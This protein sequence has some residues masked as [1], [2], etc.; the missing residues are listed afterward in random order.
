LEKSQNYDL[1]D[2]KPEKYYF[3]TVPAWGPAFSDVISY[4]DK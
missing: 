2:L 3:C 1:L 4:E